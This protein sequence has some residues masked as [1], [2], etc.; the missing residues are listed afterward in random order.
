MDAIDGVAHLSDGR[1]VLKVRVRVAPEDGAANRAVEKVIA[2]ALEVPVSRVAVAAGATSRL[3]QVRVE[4]EPLKLLD[5][6]RACL[7]EGRG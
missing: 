4:G 6:L 7:R 1:C 3:K 5:M 2:R